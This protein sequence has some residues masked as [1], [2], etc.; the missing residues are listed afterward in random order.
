MFEMLA[1][2]ILGQIAPI[3]TN[4]IKSIFSVKEKGIEVQKIISENDVKVAQI[5][6]DISKTE[7]EFEI[8]RQK[9]IAATSKTGIAWVDGLNGLVR[10]I[11]GLSAAVII[12]S[13]VILYF[14][15]RGGLLDD[16]AL[17]GV[18]SFVVSYYFSERSCQ[19]VF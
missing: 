6:A 13:S 2:G 4:L 11:I 9:T 12:L 19:K 16:K 10:V 15:G 3:A 17:A 1:G 7:N 8:E 5:K 14:I 18:V